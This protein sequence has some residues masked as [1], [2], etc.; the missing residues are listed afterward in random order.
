MNC[1]VLQQKL[2]KFPGGSEMWAKF[3]KQS[4]RRQRWKDRISQGT[5]RIPGDA[6][7]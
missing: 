3:G 7:K 6:H 2:T 1:T 5:G 4:L